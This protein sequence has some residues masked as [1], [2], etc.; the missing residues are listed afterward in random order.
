MEE[1]LKEFGLSHNEIQVYLALLKTGAS[2]ANRI[3]A[4][5]GIKRTTCYD[6]LKLLVSKGIVSSF[7]REG[8]HFFECA[9]PK[10]LVDIIKDKQDR[11]E[12]IVPQLEKIQKVIPKRSTVSLFEGK[13][14]FVNV[15]EDIFDTGQDFL[16]YGSRK[17]AELSLRHYPNLAHRRGQLGL[18]LRGVFS[19]HDRLDPVYSDTSLRK[20]TSMRFLKELDGV[21]AN[22]F[23]FGSKVAI[24][25]SG[26][27]LVGVVVE[28]PSILKQQKK[29]FELLW[30]L[31][32]R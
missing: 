12:R 32:K 6:S 10:K 7:I 20:L 29:I 4:L 27:D 18:R 25:S 2:T 9:P 1:E 8:K 17:S 16:F 3:A 28:S 15:I 14:G 23:I 21:E 13:R 24:L 30:R 11:L 22:T 26:E 19:E 5:T 31:G